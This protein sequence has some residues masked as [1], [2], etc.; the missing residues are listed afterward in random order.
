MFGFSQ[1]RKL[2]L[3]L[4]RN[5][6]ILHSIIFYYSFISVVAKFASGQEFF[7][8]GFFKLYALEIVMIAGYALCWQRV[9]KNIDLVTA[10]A[11]KGIVIIWN[12]IWGVI[13]FGE[14][15]TANN[16]IGAIIV[17]VGIYIVA[18]DDE[19]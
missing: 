9:I 14:K 18:K 11:N 17:I 12:L 16:I 10:Y 8:I 15:V 5:F 2:K 1:A 4:M 19:R 6:L 7:S 3:T 13:L